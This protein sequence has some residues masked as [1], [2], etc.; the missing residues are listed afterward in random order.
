VADPWEEVQGGPPRV[1]ASF[2]PLYCFAKNVA[3]PDAGVLSMLVTVGPHEY[4]F[5]PLDAYKAQKADLFL[6]NGLGLDNFVGELVNKSANHR[7]KVVDLGKALDEK[8][9][10][11][12]EKEAG[13]HHDHDGHD[14]EHGYYDP[15]VWLGVQEAQAMVNII[16]RVLKEADPRHAAGYEHRAKAYNQL[17]EREV[18]DYGKEAFRDKKN[19]R[20]VATHD[21]FRYFARSF[22]LEV[23]AAIQPQ[24][25]V[26][27]DARMLAD[28]RK[29][30]EKAKVRVITVEPQYSHATAETLG[31]Q[32][33]NKVDVR[34]VTVDPLETAEPADLNEGFYVRRMRANIDALAKNLE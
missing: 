12:R 34:I 10:L 18:L 19:K 2:P 9:L 16:A 28:L 31:N 33:R 32:L 26:E 1:L 20:F 4:R 29:V 21:S 13:H 6:A 5:N 22:D 17:L 8:L 30:C 3:G 23:V 14:H 25:G 27:A 7:L 24:P 15:H 11:V